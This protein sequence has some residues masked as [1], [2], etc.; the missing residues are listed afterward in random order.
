MADVVPGMRSP[1]AAGD[2]KAR[3]DSAGMRGGVVIVNEPFVELV[4]GGRNPI[5][6]H[7]RY[8][9]FEE[10]DGSEPMVPGAWHEIVGVVPDLGMAVGADVGQAKG[11]D[12]K[13]AGIYHP[14]SP[15]AAY[16][17]R[18]AIHVRGDPAALAPV[19]SAAATAVNPG[20]RL[21][22]LGPLDE[23]NRAELQ[24]LALWFRLVLGVSVIALFLSLAGIYAVMAFTVARRTREIG[25]RVA[26]GASRRGVVLAIF[27]RPL[28]QV[29]G[30]IAAGTLLVVSIMA[31]V[32]GNVLAPRHVALVVGYALLMMLV[33]LLACIVPTRRA[34]GVE[35]MEVLREE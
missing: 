1:D 28:A 4:L 5:G 12:P 20:L 18:L 29:A 31:A 10:W 19:L 26:L 35:P 16:P 24:F 2:P 3:A 25:I 32:E 21:Y 23:A 15:A 34:L 13:V 11:G 27:R 9:H 30:G 33:C 8:V 17:V 14:V 7:I 6:R 22:E